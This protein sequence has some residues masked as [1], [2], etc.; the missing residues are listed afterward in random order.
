MREHSA[1]SDQ[2]ILSNELK[3][4]IAERLKRQEQV[5]LL[6]NRR[7]YSNFMQCRECGEVVNCPNCDVSLTY[8]KP[9][10]KLKCHYC[11]FEHFIL[12]RCPS[13]QSEELRF[14]GL[15]TKRSRNIYKVSLKKQ[16]LCEWMLIQPPKRD[17]IKN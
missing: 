12:K 3:E 9:N 7:G 11:G 13:C 6:L 4:A 16:E 2:M 15:G 1:V 10:Q 5:V 14:F 8:H 17:R